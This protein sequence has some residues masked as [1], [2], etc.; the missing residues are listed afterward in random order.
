M[1]D[2][3]DESGD[4]AGAASLWSHMRQPHEG[5]HLRRHNLMLS[6]A[7]TWE[8][9]LA[10]LI[11]SSEDFV[12]IKVRVLNVRNAVSGRPGPMNLRKLAKC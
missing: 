12:K 1:A 2:C 4:G 11:I 6:S 3:G 8:I 10:E 5:V 7:I 9:I